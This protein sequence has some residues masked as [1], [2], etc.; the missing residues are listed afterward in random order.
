MRITNANN[1]N[2]Q[3]KVNFGKM[4]F[5]KSSSNIIQNMT[6]KEQKALMNYKSELKNTKFYKS[7]IMWYYINVLERSTIMPR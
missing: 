3:P 1:A 7:Q 2:Y 5:D 4:V 6:S